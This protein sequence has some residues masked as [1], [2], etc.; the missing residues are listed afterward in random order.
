M[1]KLLLLGIVSILGLGLLLISGLTSPT[2]NLIEDYGEIYRVNENIYKH[3]PRHWPKLD[4]IPLGVTMPAGYPTQTELESKQT[5]LQ[6]N[7]IPIYPYAYNTYMPLKSGKINTFSGRAGPYEE[8]PSAY[9]QGKLCSYAYKIS[10]APL[11]CEDIVLG[12]ENKHVTFA[13]GYAP[14]EYIAYQAAGTNFAAIFILTSPAYGI[15]GESPT[16]YLKFTDK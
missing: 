13:R 4:Y 5:T 12:Y 14:D 7:N 10:G 9:L 11:R 16:A 2:G 6:V 1:G 8:D 3:A 15:V